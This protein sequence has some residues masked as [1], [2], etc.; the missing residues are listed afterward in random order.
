[1]TRDY[2][3]AYEYVAKFHKLDK[4]F[5]KKNCMKGITIG[6]PA[7]NEEQN[8]SGLLQALEAQAGKQVKEIII[9]DD[10]TDGT[11]DIVS[12]HARR[13]HIDIVHMHHKKRRGAAA[14][15]TEIFSRAQ[16]DAIV[17][18]DADTLPAPRCT[19]RLAAS[20]GGNGLVASNS[21]PVPAGGMAGRAS[22]FISHWLRSVRKAG[23]SKYTVMGR[24]LAIDARAAKKIA[25]PDHIIAIDLYLQCR[26]LEMGLGVA[27]DDD[28]VVYFRPAQNMQD[29]ASQV[30]RAVN[31]HNQID[32]YVQRL[33]LDLP[34]TRTLSSAAKAIRV[35]P[36]GAV[37]AAIGYMHLP[38]YRSRLAG[39][40][41]A[42]WHTAASS[43]SR[44]D[45]RHV[46][47]A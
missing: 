21:Q 30:L 42:L 12:A 29:L 9:S 26:V 13:S 8:I 31:G 35:D 41:S 39:A 43:K 5:L 32:E 6:I 19:A 40:N 22:A 3:A 7:Y 36:V 16:G 1:M 34:L 14:A 44:I 33:G 11:P 37:S 45:P 25:I 27:Y 17:L 28:A 4:T 20:L 24:G 46:G 38:R 10:S 2:V 18:Y 47:M 23:L 15:W